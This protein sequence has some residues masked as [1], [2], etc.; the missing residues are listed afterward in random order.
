MVINQKSPNVVV[1]NTKV[2]LQDICH[3]YRLVGR[4]QGSRGIFEGYWSL[5]SFGGVC[6]FL[7]SKFILNIVNFVFLFSK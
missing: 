2:V 1:G 7:L 6:P 3:H 5:Y 4:R